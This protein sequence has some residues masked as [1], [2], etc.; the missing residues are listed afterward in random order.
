VTLLRCLLLRDRD[1]EAWEKMKTM[2]HHN[3]VRKSF[4]TLWQRNQNN[5]VK[6]LRDWYKLKDQFD[7]ETVNSV[8]GYIDVN[9]FEIKTKVIE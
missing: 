1:L 4:S 2:E 6:L 7:E 8:L 5:S 3:D 9:S